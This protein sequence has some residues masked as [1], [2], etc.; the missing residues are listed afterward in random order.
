MNHLSTGRTGVSLLVVLKNLG[1]VDDTIMHISLKYVCMFKTLEIPHLQHFIVILG[2]PN[3]FRLI[4]S[5][6]KYTV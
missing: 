4:D 2:F 5:S 1:A 6:M 3:V